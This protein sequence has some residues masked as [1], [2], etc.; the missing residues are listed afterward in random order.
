MTKTIPGGSFL[1]ARTVF[2]SAIWNKHP[3]Y[4]RLFFW[5]VGN[6]NH[7]DGYTFKGHIL[8]R[9]QL[10]TTY[11]AIA[12]ALSYCFNKSIIRPTLKEI[13]IMLSWLQSEGMIT[14][15]PLIDGTLTHKGRHPDLT[16]AYVGLLISIVNYDPYQRAESYKGRDKGRHPDAQGQLEQLQTIKTF[17]SDSIEIRLSEL[18]FEK[19]LSRNPNHKRP[20]L[21]TWAKDIDRMIRIDHRTPEDIR[22]VIDWCQS[23]P[24]WQ[25]NILSTAKLREKFDQLCLKMGTEGKSESGKPWFPGGGHE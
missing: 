15:K 11:S 18:L 13:R 25:N 14:V 5:I 16:R 3:Q 9:G 20:N 21:Q 6:A 8:S 22:A 24:F 12:D 7:N 10:I 17:L 1:W 23:D 19:I 4:F 2:Q